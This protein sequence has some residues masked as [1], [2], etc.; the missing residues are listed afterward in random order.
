MIFNEEPVLL[1]AELGAK[2]TAENEYVDSAPSL[3]VTYFFVVD[4]VCLYVCMYVCMSVCLSRQ[5]S[6][7]FF[8]FVSRWNRA[9]FTVI[10]TFGTLQN[11]IFGLGPITPKFTP[12][13]VAQNRL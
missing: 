11:V 4:S 1:A 13:N 2:V 7:R 8:I 10:S 3:G 12:Q 9:I 5:T 6:N